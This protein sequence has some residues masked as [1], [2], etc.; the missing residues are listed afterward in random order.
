[1][2]TTL[3]I[4]ILLATAQPTEQPQTEK[5]QQTAFIFKDQQAFYNVSKR[6]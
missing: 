6:K 1:M 4:S 5:V 3:A 2:L